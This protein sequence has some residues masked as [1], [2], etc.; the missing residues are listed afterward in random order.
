MWLIPPD[1]ESD[2]DVAELQRHVT[3]ERPDLL[4]VGR[5]APRQL[6]R[7][8]PDFG[9]R[10]DARLL[11][12]PVP[13]CNFSPAA[14]AAELHIGHRCIVRGLSCVLIARLGT[15]QVR[16][17][18]AI[19]AISARV[20]YCRLRLRALD[21]D[22][23]SGG[24]LNRQLLAQHDSRFQKVIVKPELPGNERRAQP[25][26]VLVLQRVAHCE[27]PHRQL[28]FLQVAVKRRRHRDLRWHV[29]HAVLRRGHHRAV[30]L[31]HLD[32]R[33]LHVGVRGGIRNAQKTKGLQPGGGLHAHPHRAVNHVRS[34]VIEAHVAGNSL[35]DER[36]C[37]II[38]RLPWLRC[39]RGKG[40]TARQ[41]DS[42]RKDRCESEREGFHCGSLPGAEILVEGP[43]SGLS[44]AHPRKQRSPLALRTLP[45]SFRITRR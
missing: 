36:F 3:V 42:N 5:G 16:R 19:R 40:R 10:R 26:G 15:H 45:P 43:T 41:R 23:T 7:L 29:L 18:P 2:S 21:L 22:R 31:G 20:A 9:R 38:S 12:L 6:F 28:F 34:V 25:V 13:L 14:K 32:V 27:S 37:R 17:F 11:Q 35:Y 44:I 4:I 30:R 33:K 8:G 24:H 1:A 39:L